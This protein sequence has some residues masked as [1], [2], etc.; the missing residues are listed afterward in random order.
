MKSRLRRFLWQDLHID[1]SKEPK[2]LTTLDAVLYAALGYADEKI[3]AIP[4]SSDALVEAL[5]TDG[6]QVRTY[7]PTK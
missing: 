6:N 5:N 3:N 1:S 2:T 7:L 4:A